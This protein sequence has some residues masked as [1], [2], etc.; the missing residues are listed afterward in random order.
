VTNRPC[1]LFDESVS[2]AIQARLSTGDLLPK[3]LKCNG[4]D[5]CSQSE[6]RPPPTSSRQVK[7]KLSPRRSFC[8]ITVQVSEKAVVELEFD[9]V[10]GEHAHHSPIRRPAVSNGGANNR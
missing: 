10:V 9:T 5:G 7:Q 8:T 2:A 4:I 1:E 3:N 6:L